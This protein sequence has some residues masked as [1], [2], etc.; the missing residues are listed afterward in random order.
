MGRIRGTRN[1]ELVWVWHSCVGGP[2]V[3]F[4]KVHQDRKDF[5]S[6]VLSHTDDECKRTIPG[7]TI[8][9]SIFRI[10][11]LLGRR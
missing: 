1:W 7:N 2:P 4:A 10:A 11:V 3:L 9:V 5:I 6:T 8:A